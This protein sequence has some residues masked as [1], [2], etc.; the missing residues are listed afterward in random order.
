MLNLIRTFGSLA[1]TLCMEVYMFQFGCFQCYFF[2]QCGAY[3]CSHEDSLRIPIIQYRNNSLLHWMGKSPPSVYMHPQSHP[4]GPL[5]H[6]V[7]LGSGPLLMTNKVPSN[8]LFS[9]LEHYSDFW[10][11]GWAT[12]QFSLC[13]FS[14]NLPLPV[15]VSSTVPLPHTPTHGLQRRALLPATWHFWLHTL[16]PSS[17]V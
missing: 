4:C 13:S 9:F 12:W 10:R 3:L 17:C 7:P 15:L 16:S 5:L 1:L 11:K 6:G 8:I 14:F 2:F